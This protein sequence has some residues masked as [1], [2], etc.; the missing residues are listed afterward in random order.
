M[1]GTS[2]LPLENRRL[3]PRG[4]SHNCAVAGQRGAKIIA[5]S[6]GRLRDASETRSKRVA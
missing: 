4:G 1:P 5:G 6:A 3:R 2:R